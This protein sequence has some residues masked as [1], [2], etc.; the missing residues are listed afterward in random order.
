MPEHGDRI[1]QVQIPRIV[2]VGGRGAREL[3]A[4]GEEKIQR[5]HWI[6]EIETAIGVRVPTHEPTLV[7]QDKNGAAGDTSRW[8]EAR[9]T[10]LR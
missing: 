8:R 2:R 7:R 1:R 6:A 10:S 4:A 3:S 9:Q 5:G